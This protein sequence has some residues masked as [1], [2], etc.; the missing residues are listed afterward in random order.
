MNA[1]AMRISG[2]SDD[3]IGYAQKLLALAET[4]GA[5]EAEVFG[6]CGRSTDVD[7]RQ[8]QVEL[9]SESFHCGLGLRAVLNGAVG[10]SST[11]DVS[12]L[13]QVAKSA[14]RAA[15]ARKGDKWWRSLPLPEKAA[16]PLQIFDQAL[17]L[18]TPEGCIEIARGMLQG[19]LQVSG[20]DP[21]SGSVSC[22]STF[23]LVVNSRGIALSERA[24]YMHA[25]MEAISRGSD[26]ATGSDFHNS[27]TLVDDLSSI[28]RAAA[29]MAKSSVG[30]VKAESGVHDVML[31]PLALAELL[32]YTLIPS[33][34]G[35]NVQKGRS[36][37]KD[38]LGEQIAS[39]HVHLVD[40]GLL[41]AGMGSSGFDGEGTPSQR[42]S[43]V[44]SGILRGFLYDSYNA[45]KADRR[46]T[47][48]ALRG[49]YSDVPR[50]GVRNLI[51]SSDQAYDLAAETRGMLVNGFIGAHTAN[52]ISGDF[53]VEARNSFYVEPGKAPRP[54][55][56]MMLAGNVFDLLKDI[57]VGTDVRVV[58]SVVTPSAKLRMKVVGG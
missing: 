42:T 5:E 3:L 9:A 36:S 17:D 43:L 10:F 15:R 22:G 13:D 23:E 21:V 27:R 20:A 28:G 2:I 14:V 11:S 41:S 35:D 47:G 24:T 26:V 57:E 45:G 29:E 52:S 51:V 33:L 30:G 44:E 1:E 49:G 18:A 31:K 32:E 56:T 4:E 12:R 6:V 7:L 40:D 50:V 25:F 8:T 34:S 38:R 39:G 46:S 53:S 16:E 58:G 48:N 19:C 37:L 54:I 55:K